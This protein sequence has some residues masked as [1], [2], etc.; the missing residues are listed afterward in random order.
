M[1]IVNRYKRVCVLKYGQLLATLLQSMN[2]SGIRTCLNS[3]YI[4][5]TMIV[6]SAKDIISSRREQIVNYFDVSN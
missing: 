4:V 1:N 2:N 5:I 6:F 3:G